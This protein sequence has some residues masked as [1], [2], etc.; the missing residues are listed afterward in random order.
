MMTTSARTSLDKMGTTERER[1]L[2]ALARAFEATR[3]ALAALGPTDVGCD[4]QEQ[5]RMA[6]GCARRAATLAIGGAPRERWAWNMEPR[7]GR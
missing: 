5:A 1:A 4:V 6:L 2:L 3:D 7:S